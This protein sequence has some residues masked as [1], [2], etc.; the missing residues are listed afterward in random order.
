ML[1]RDTFKFGGRPVSPDPRQ[2]ITIRLRADV[3]EEW[4]ATGTGWMTRMAARLR[5]VR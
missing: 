4:R 1:R 3:I 5:K 2:Q